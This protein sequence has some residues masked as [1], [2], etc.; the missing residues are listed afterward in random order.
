MHFNVQNFIEK[1]KGKSCLVIGDIILD[2]YIHGEVNRISP[3]APIPIVKVSDEEYVLGGAANVAGNIC[4]YH[5]KV[6]L[7]GLLGHDKDA[8]IVQK[9]LKEKFIDFVGMV[10]DKR[11]TTMKTRIIGMNQQL[12]RVDREEVIEITNLE[13]AQLLKNLM[14][15]IHKVQ[16]IVLSDYNKGVCSSH[17]CRQVME[18]CNKMNKRVIIDPKSSNWTKYMGAYLITPN[19]KEFQEVI[20]H[21]FKNTE[22]VIRE[23]AEGIL[24][25]YK[26]DQILVTRS[27]YGMTLVRRGTE[28]SLTIRSVQQEVFDVSGAGDTVIAS[29][30]ALLAVDI[31]IEEALEMSNYAA[32][33][34]VSKAGTYMVSLEEVVEY[35]NRTGLWYENKIWDINKLIDMLTKWRNAKE[36]VVFTNG[37]FDIL[38]IGHIDYLNRARTLGDKM[39]VGLNTDASVRRLKGTTRPVNDQNARALAL[40]ALQCIDGVVLFDEDTPEDL[41]RIV[42]PDFLVKGGDY[43]ISEIVGWQYA[44]ETKVIPLTEGHSTTNLIEKIRKTFCHTL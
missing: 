16:I 30:A 8:S 14:K 11:C 38:H 25:R 3:E 29:I 33:L 28:E 20:G 32:G 19:F 34:S 21:S 35:S 40:A 9:L 12:V 15:V 41:V 4:G 2:K 36:K 37:C 27:Q 22:F 39:I 43:K 5:I 31:P 42:K 17:F 1:A 24:D 23:K 44:K 13:E 18:I 7:C 6:Y 10:S 26:L